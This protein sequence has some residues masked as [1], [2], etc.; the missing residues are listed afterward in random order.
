MN[1]EKANKAVEDSAKTCKEAT[2]KVDKLITHAQAFMSTFQSS[3]K[4]NIAKANEAISCLSVSLH[5]KNE[6]LEKVHTGIKSD[7]FELN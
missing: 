1:L 5:T 7:N 2:E 6:A 3:F 4:S